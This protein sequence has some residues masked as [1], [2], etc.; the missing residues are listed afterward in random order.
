VVSLQLTLDG[1][2]D[3]AEV[4]TPNLSNGETR[5]G[6]VHL[7]EADRARVSQQTVNVLSEIAEAMDNVG[8]RLV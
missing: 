7:I 3:L 8:C 1:L 5:G 4:A 6:S 2:C